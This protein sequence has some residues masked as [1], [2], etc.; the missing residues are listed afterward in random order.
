MENRILDKKS[1][2]FP[3]T[4]ILTHSP[5]FSRSDLLQDKNAIERM[6][7]D[8]LRR[9][10]EMD[11]AEAEWFEDEKVYSA[12][13]DRAKASKILSDAFDDDEIELGLRA[14]KIRP[15]GSGAN[16]ADSAGSGATS[17]S[18][19]DPKVDPETLPMLSLSVL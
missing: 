16:D 11:E 14:S 9:V 6:K 7:R 5:P 19:Y 4:Y 8:I 1:A 13:K 3:I 15:P 12:T 17:D 10:E 2:I 18:E